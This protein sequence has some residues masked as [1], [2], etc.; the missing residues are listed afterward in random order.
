MAPSIH[1]IIPSIRE[2][3]LASIVGAG[4]EAKITLHV[5][6]ADTKAARKVT[7]TLF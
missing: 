5:S 4:W 1:A 6:T 2:A 3:G 7:R